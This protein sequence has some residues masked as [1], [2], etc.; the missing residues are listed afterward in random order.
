MH[1]A[2]R[3]PDFAFSGQNG[4]ERLPR[5]DGVLERAIDQMETAADEIHKLGVEL[6]LADLGVVEGPHEPIRIIVENLA[7]LGLEFTIS[8]DETV[9][10]KYDQLIA[11][12]FQNVYLYPGGMFEWLHLQDVYG[13]QEF[14][15]T[16]KILDIL[17]YKPTRVFG[18]RLI[19]Y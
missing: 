14:P 19:G 2:Q 13:V 3:P 5:G 12:G 18:V 8:N 11:L 9:E 4:E 1:E 6:E 16:S 15:T 17:K 7:R 10:K